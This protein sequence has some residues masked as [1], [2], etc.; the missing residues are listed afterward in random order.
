MP[1]H[2]CVICGRVKYFPPFEEKLEVRDLCRQ[3]DKIQ[4]LFLEKRIK[5]VKD[6]GER[7]R[8]EDKKGK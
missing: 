8:K 6:S 3:C 5:E 1:N 2:I 4:D 7:R